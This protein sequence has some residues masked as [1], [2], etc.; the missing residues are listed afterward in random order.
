MDARAVDD[1]FVTGG[2]RAA[3]ETAGTSSGAFGVAARERFWGVPRLS[4]DTK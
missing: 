1:F 2:A 3:A 4:R